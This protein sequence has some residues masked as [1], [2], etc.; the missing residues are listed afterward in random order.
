MLALRKR[1]E[2]KRNGIGGWPSGRDDLHAA[3]VTEW[4]R[5]KRLDGVV[6]TA[7]PPKWNDENGRVPTEAEVLDYLSAQ[8]S[9]AAGES[10]RYIRDAPPQIQ[11]PYRIALATLVGA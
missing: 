1:E 11:T 10:L 2:T 4:A 3:C 5:A 9:E 7:L 6:W 8:P